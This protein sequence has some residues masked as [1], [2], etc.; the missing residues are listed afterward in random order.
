[1][2]SSRAWNRATNYPNPRSFEA[3]EGRVV[4]LAAGET[5]RF[6]LQLIYHPDSESLARAERGCR[7]PS[8]KLDA[9]ISL[10][11]TG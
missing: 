8:R 2:A 11:T 3:N 7:V 5:R 9:G 1:M 4:P 10:R 6:D